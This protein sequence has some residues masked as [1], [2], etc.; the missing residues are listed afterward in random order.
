MFV[1]TSSISRDLALTILLVPWVGGGLRPL[2][3]SC[4]DPM[5]S[6]NVLTTTALAWSGSWLEM[7][8]LGPSLYQLNQ[9]TVEVTSIIEQVLQSQSWLWPTSKTHSDLGWKNQQVS[10]LTPAGPATPETNSLGFPTRAPVS[11]VGKVLPLG[12]TATC[13]HITLGCNTS[14]NLFLKYKGAYDSLS[15]NSSRNSPFVASFVL[16]TWC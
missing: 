6:Q 9:K 16:D 1:S 4:L 12:L 10:I 13:R 7:P 2:A 14:V 3:L 5:S 15:Q 8:V 11:T